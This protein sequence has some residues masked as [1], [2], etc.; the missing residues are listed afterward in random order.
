LSRV[1]QRRPCARESTRL[2]AAE[3]RSCRSARQAR[4]IGKSKFAHG[5]ELVGV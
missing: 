5:C 1:R 4:S 2:N 3:R